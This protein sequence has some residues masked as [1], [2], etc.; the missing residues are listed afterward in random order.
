MTIY[1]LNGREVSRR[2]FLRRRGK[3]GGAG[4]PMV[5]Q[6]YSE[7]RPLVSQ[8]LG[9]PPSQAAMMDEEVRKE[10]IAGVRYNA[11]GECVITS[12][13]GRAAW[14]KKFGERVGI[15]NVHDA[16]GGCGDG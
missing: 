14:M 4:V 6:A 13:D 2:E 7:S 16:D 3:L 8:A 5:N 10:G 15:A 11:L 1:R 12:R 9:V